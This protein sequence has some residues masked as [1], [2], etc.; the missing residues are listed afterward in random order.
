MSDLPDVNCLPAAYLKRAH[1]L[2]ESLVSGT[3]TVRVD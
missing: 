1:D 3:Y 2:W